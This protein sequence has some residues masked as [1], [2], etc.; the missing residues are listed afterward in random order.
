MASAGRP[1]GFG[2][3]LPIGLDQARESA[4]LKWYQSIPD[5]VRTRLYGQV[6]KGCYIEEC[7]WHESHVV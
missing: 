7:T 2:S 6:G 3:D 1:R 4:H 5:P